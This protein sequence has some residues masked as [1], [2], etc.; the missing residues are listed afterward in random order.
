MASPFARIELLTDRNYDLWKIKVS[1]LI[2]CRHLLD[3][4]KVR[5][6]PRKVEGA[7]KVLK[8]GKLG[9]RKMMK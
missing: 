8:I 6:E 5:D 2:K 4:V 9:R 7:K 3:D 1:A